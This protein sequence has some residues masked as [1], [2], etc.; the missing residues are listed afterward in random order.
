MTQPEIPALTSALEDYLETIYCLVEEQGFARVKGISK[1]R[2][3]KAASVSIALRRL[4]ELGLVRYERRE[5]ITLTEEGEQ[6]GRRVYARHQLLT[7]FF[8]EVLQMPKTASSEQACAMEHSLS[9]QAMD[10]LAHFFEFQQTEGAR[11]NLRHLADMKPGE[12]AKVAHV[13]ARGA[14]RQRLLDMGILPD[15]LIELERVGLRGDPVWIRCQGS[16]LALRQ[17]EARTVLVKP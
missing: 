11:K 15:V 3:V 13:N 9:D 4:E 2:G 16:Q 8:N 12:K 1:A 6:Q 7:R 10:R 5:Y 17:S 14:I